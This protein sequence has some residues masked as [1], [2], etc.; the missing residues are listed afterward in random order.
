LIFVIALES[1]FFVDWN[2]GLVHFISTPCDP[3]APTTGCLGANP[4]N[5]CVDLG[6]TPGH[7]GQTRMLIGLA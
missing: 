6:I 2:M 7:V 5:L 3:N 1:M 4:Q